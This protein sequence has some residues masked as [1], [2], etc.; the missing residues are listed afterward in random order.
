MDMRTAIKSQ[1][2]AALAMLEQAVVEC[3][4][5]VWYGTSYKNRFWHIAYHALFYTHLY[6]QDKLEDFVPWDKH[7]DT[8]SS[9]R[10]PETP[11]GQAADDHAPFSQ[12]EIQ[13]YLAIC[14]TV[15]EEKTAGLDLNAE[16][17]FHWLPFGKLELQLYNLRHLQQHTGELCERLGI[18]AKVD[19]DWVA[20]VHDA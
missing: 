6:L 19:V 18:N 2:L 14:R 5:S 12:D 11:E 20:M 9:L 1:Y 3:P 16:S 17:G 7:S 10:P 15:V 13:E 4:E 8:Y